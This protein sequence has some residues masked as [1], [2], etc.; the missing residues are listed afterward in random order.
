[1]LQSVASAHCSFL[2]F[3]TLP[4][5]T[6]TQLATSNC[7]S[8]SIAADKGCADMARVLVVIMLSG[9]VIA[10]LAVA[11]ARSEQVPNPQSA[12]ESASASDNLPALP[13]E[14]Q[15]KSTVLGGEIMSVDRVRD[16][17]TLKV[18]GQRPTKILFD[19]RT[20]VYCDGQKIPL[21]D[22]TS[23]DHAS[24]QTLL[25]GT[26]VFALSIHILSRSPEGE[27]QGSV[28]NYNPATREL[29]VGALQFRNPIKLLLPVN[30]RILRKGQ[31]PFSS[32]SSGAPDLVKGTFISV[33]FESDKDGRSVATQIAV[34]AT[35]G[36]TFVFSGNLS[37]LD[38]HSGSLVLVDPRDDKSYQ[39][40]F[41]PTQL[42]AS[43]N[44]HE[45]DSVRVI[46]TFDGTRYVARAIAFN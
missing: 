27:F 33:S 46:A 1:M 39:I 21:R 41:D 10:Q 13:P 19:E 42:P 20:Q 38:M 44:L 5:T 45:G 37:S 30:T 24:V 11:S 43:R 23:A 2:S 17:L 12:L 29:T 31:G 35:P 34:L 32:A 6:E 9:A 36:S 25:D 26:N 8:S 15:G 14:P 16:E 7:L 18:F 22:L 28:L 4:W 40:V 3:H